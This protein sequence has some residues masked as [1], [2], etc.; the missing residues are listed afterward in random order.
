MVHITGTKGK[1]STS[2]FTDSI[3]RH[4]KPQWKIG[5]RGCRLREAVPGLTCGIGLYTSP[6]LVAVRER[7]RIDGAPISEEQFAEF[8]FDVWDR[9]EQNDEVSSARA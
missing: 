1:G 9:L 4:A 7:I 6:H 3:L 2:A 8:F 5:E